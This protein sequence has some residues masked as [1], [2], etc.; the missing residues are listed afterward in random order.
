MEIADLF[1]DES[2]RLRTVWRF[3]IFGASLM[4]VW[5]TICLVV[6]AGLAEFLKGTGRALDVGALRAQLEEAYLLIFAV[7]LLPM[8]VGTFGVVW[9]CRRLL[10]R[11]SLSSLGLMKPQRRLTASV[12]VGMAAAA[13]LCTLSVAVLL[14]LGRLRFTGTGG[15]ALTA[16]LIPVF[17]VGAFQEELVVRGY[18]LQNMLDVRRPVWGVLFS[19]AVFSLMHSLNPGVWTSALPPFN[20]FLAGVVLALAYMVSGNLWFPSAVHFM[21]NVCQGAV[22][23]IPV[24]GMPVDGWLPLAQVGPGD[25]MISGG[26]FGLEGSLVLVL[27][28]GAV[29]V[30]LLA[31]LYHRWSI[32]SFRAA[33][34]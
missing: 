3:L 14:A 33:W 7:V 10:D 2:R 4:A 19:S 18:L 22:F 26:A 23:G 29:I 24:S 27:L 13:L 12:W 31:I 1:L 34:R 8:A 20:L 30:V 15:S 11:R 32:L 17:V 25:D 5:L 6:A 21:W 16:V 28:Q 9:L